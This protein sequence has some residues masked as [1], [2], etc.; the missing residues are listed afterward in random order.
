MKLQIHISNEYLP[1]RLSESKSLEI[2]LSEINSFKL[3][4]KERENEGIR[5]YLLGYILA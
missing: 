3:M 4:Q 2:S 1:L 5:V